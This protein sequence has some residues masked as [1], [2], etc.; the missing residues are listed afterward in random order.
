MVSKSFG[1]IGLGSV[2]WAVVHGL[3]TR[4]PYAVY[5]IVGD[6]V[7]NNILSTDIVFLCVPTPANE[8]GR[9]DCSAVIDVLNHLDK[10]KYS[11]CIVIKSTVFIGFMDRVVVQ[12][13]ALRIVY[14]PEF[15]REKSSFTWFADPDRLV[16]SGSDTDIMEVLSY[17]SWVEKH[18]PVLRMNYRSAEVGKLAHNAYIATKV[19]FTNEM[20]AICAEYN[21]NAFDVMSVIWADRRVHSQDHLTPNLGPYGGKC[22]PKDVNELLHSGKKRILLSA[23]E[24]VNA[25]TK[26]KSKETCEPVV[27]T[28]IPTHNRPIFLDRAISSVSSQKKKPNTIYIVI[29]DDD[30]SYAAVEKI[31]AHF[32][33]IIS[34][35]LIKNNRSHNLSGA[36]NTALEQ[37]C[38]DY[39]DTS[40]VFVSILDDDDW[41]DM[42]YLANVS[43]YALETGAD[44][45]ISG[46]I[47]HDD[48]TQNG[49][50]QTIPAKITPN[51]FFYTN[52]N[53]QGSNLFVRLS[54]LIAIGGFDEN[55]ASTTDRDVC[56]RLLDINSVPATLNNHLVHHD[57][58]HLRDRLSSVGSKKKGQGLQYF[59]DKYEERM[60]QTER[61]CFKKRSEDLFRICIAD[62][63]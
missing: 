8:S 13:P 63:H 19:S 38:A 41:W 21:A 4:F 62:R 22:V 29:D 59:Y 32:G 14:M 58:D 6:Y 34:V 5:D 28:V 40:N 17:F 52:P 15:L 43:K 27:I 23:V 26:V 1:V 56:I 37:A 51:A 3:S 48:A 12:Y 30:P 20:E 36:V 7:W 39:P 53:I 61:E 24:S 25:Q 60:S 2:G 55:L 9:L 42:S 11:G 44:W 16:I 18:V 54:N 49:M 31:V 46:L 45:I 57:A 47:R 10:D 33:T 50:M 35:N